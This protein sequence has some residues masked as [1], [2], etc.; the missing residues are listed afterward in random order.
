MLSVCGDG[1][2]RFA[3]LDRSD[4]PWMVRRLRHAMT[5]GRPIYKLNIHSSGLPNRSS[6]NAYSP[7]EYLVG[8]PAYMNAPVSGHGTKDF[9]A[10][11][12]T[13]NTAVFITDSWRLRVSAT[14]PERDTDEYLREVPAT[15]MHI[16]TL[17]AGEDVR[18]PTLANPPSLSR[19][20]CCLRSTTE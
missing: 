2:A 15:R 16:L 20:H 5:E 11:D 6:T 14:R 17:P 13:E 9:V 10:L 8:W 4:C 12:L 18:A 1:Y 19:S 3:R 7:Q